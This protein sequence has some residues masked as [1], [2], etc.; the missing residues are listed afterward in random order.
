M[1]ITLRQLKVFERVARRLSF[2]RAAEEL[3]LTQPA[4]SMQIKQFEDV[5]GLPL[6]ERLGKKIYLTRAGEE[7]YRLSRTISLQLEEAEQLIEELKGTE[8]GRLAV[9]VASTVHYFAIRL[10]ADFCRRYPKVKVSFKVTNRKGLLQQLDD[11]EADIVLMGQPPEDQ[12]LTAEAFM[13]NP[14]VVIAPA[15]HPLA[16]QKSIPLSELNHETFLMREQGSGTRNAVER[17]LSEKGVQ[18]SASMEMNTNGAI[19]QGV[20]E[21]LGLGIVSIHT[22]ERELEDGRVV[23]LDAESF[24]IMRQWYI[25]H[26]AGKRLSAVAREFEEFVRTEAGRFVNSDIITT[27]LNGKN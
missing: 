3:Y 5:I 23:V 17:F 12:D 9:S 20:E 19:K 26:R 8:G 2:T 27:A 4:V 6:F 22:V 25:V 11:N 16:G 1:N 7:L 10:L 21:G 14:L 13:D 24:P 15:N 18:I